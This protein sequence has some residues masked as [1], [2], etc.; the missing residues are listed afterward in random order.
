MWTITICVYSS[1]LILTSALVAGLSAYLFILSISACYRVLRTKNNHRSHQKEQ[2]ANFIILIPVH[3]EQGIIGDTLDDLLSLNY[4]RE[5]METIVIAD[6]CTDHTAHIAQQ[7]GCA[8]LERTDKNKTGKNRA[9]NWAM[10]QHLRDWPRDYDAVLFIDVDS[11]LNQDF[12][13]HMSRELHKGHELLQGYDTVVN[14]DQ[15]WRSAVQKAS[16]KLRNYLRPLGREGLGLP[17]GLRG[18]G[19]VVSR[20][21]IEKYG[22]PTH[23]RL[24]DIELAFFYKTKNVDVK[25]VPAAGVHEKRRR[26]KSAASPWGSDWHHDRIAVIRK[27]LPRL[28]KR[29]LGQQDL[30]S[31]D[32]L[33]ELIVPPFFPLISISGVLLAL[34]MIG[35]TVIPG[36]LPDIALYLTVGAITGQLIYLLA[37][38]TLT[39]TSLDIW[40]SV[41]LAPAFILRDAYQQLRGHIFSSDSEQAVDESRE[42]DDDSRE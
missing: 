24:E 13:W 26:D 25:F 9:L 15:D 32:S 8:V 34:S 1:L 36:A 14:E 6:H 41:L 33:L 20:Q 7:K 5:R 42:E 12:L 28:L 18:N 30:S 38:L 39:R 27:W 11:R 16:A 35:K 17:C 23:T 31:L 4:P 22:Y 37:G 21:L 19:F 29:A 40:T 3:N 10:E 2:T